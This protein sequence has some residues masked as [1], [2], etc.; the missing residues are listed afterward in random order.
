MFTMMQHQSM[1]SNMG[2]SIVSSWLRA[3]HELK[4]QYAYN[5]VEAEVNL[6]FEQLMF[7]LA[8][9]IYE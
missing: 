3:L 5:E 6:V 2:A 8:R 9:G 7:L 4:R 1:A